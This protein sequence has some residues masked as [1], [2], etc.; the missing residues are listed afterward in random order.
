MTDYKLTLLAY[1]EKD[2]KPVHDLLV[3]CPSAEHDPC[4]DYFGFYENRDIPACTSGY[5]PDPMALIVAC[6]VQGWMPVFPIAGYV[7]L[8][9]DIG[10]HP[11]GAKGIKGRGPN[12]FAALTD[13][14]LQATKTLE[15]DNW[16]RCDACGG[17]GNMIGQEGYWVNGILADP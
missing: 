8:T 3:K 2:G 9:P 13:A 14:L 11:W 5:L 10:H 16:T 12:N 1:A 15:P 4:S 6:Q 17:T 7:R